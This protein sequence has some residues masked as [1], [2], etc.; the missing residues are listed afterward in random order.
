MNPAEV[1]RQLRR[2]AKAKTLPPAYVEKWLAFGE[3]GRARLLEIAETLKMHTGQ[4]VSALTLLE[5][6]SL[7][8]G[9]DVSEILARPT[10][11]RLLDSPG[12]GPGRARELLSELR[13]LRYPG[14][15]RASQRLRA[16]LAAIKL[17]RGINVVLPRDLASDE[18]RIEIVANGS[19]KLEQLLACLAAKSRE[20]VGLAAM[21][22]GAGRFE[23][24]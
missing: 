12:S 3:C 16:E 24:E 1:D 7:R 15:E 11:R 9:Q 22:A 21:L 4:L 23:V 8:E 5:E 19:A 6:I 13:T 14:L 18:I 17:P 10:L 2:W 20:L